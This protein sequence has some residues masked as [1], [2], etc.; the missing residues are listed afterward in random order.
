MTNLQRTTRFALG[1]CKGSPNV[2]NVSIERVIVISIHDVSKDPQN[3]ESVVSSN[4]DS[5]KEEWGNRFWA[6]I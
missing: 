6:S 1:G 5:V 4:F 2:R 3:S